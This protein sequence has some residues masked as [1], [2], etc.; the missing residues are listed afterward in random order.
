[1]RDKKTGV[2]AFLLTALLL[3]GCGK[4]AAGTNLGGAVGKEKERMAEEHYGTGIQDGSNGYGTGTY[5]GGTAYWDGYGINSGR[6]MFGDKN[7][8]KGAGEEIRDAADDVGRDI[9]NA[10]DDLM[11]GGKTE[12][13]LN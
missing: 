4:D 6:E 1:M 8:L 2:L 12:Q 3:S 9:R 7:G 10:A 5:S 11:D 13:A